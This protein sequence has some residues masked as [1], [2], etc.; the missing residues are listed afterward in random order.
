L[1][2]D[3]AWLAAARESSGAR[4]VLWLQESLL[5]ATPAGDALQLLTPD[6]LTPTQR[7]AGSLLGCDAAGRAYFW[8]DAGAAPAV[9][10]QAVGLRALAG[11]ASAFDAGLAAY[12]LALG[13]WQRK[14]RYCPACCNAC[15]HDEAGHRALHGL[16][17][18]AVP[19]H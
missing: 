6:A 11:S 9:P 3:S 10:G 8:C 12:A 14:S 16:R 17:H 18:R 1:R 5:W 13:Y 7:S 2:R 19:A 4:Y 15:T